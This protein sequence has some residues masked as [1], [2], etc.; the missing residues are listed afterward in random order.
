MCETP[1]PDG[2]GMEVVNYF[3]MGDYLS[4]ICGS[5]KNQSQIK[6]VV[7]QNYIVFNCQKSNIIYFRLSDVEDVTELSQSFLEDFIYKKPSI[8]VSVIN[9][10]K[11]YDSESLDGGIKLR[12]ATSQEI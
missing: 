7:S 11:L 8:K 3:I 5:V 2:D 6:Y 4:K 9:L 1:P 10:Q 12:V